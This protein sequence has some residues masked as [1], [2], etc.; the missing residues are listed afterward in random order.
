MLG[1]G[2]GSLYVPILLYC[3]INFHTA[4]TTS[5]LMLTSGSLSAVYVF[6][7][8]GM[9]D[10]KLVTVLGIPSMLG[11]FIGGLIS[12][13]FNVYAL[14]IIFSVTLFIASY[15][16]I[17]EN[18]M[19]EG[20]SYHFQF[21]PFIMHRSFQ[22]NKYRVDLVL[23]GILV[24]LVGFLGGLIGVAGGWFIVPMLV[25]LFS[26]PMR[27]AVATSSVVVLLNGT[28]GITGHGLA[29]HINWQLALWLSI[30]A[31]IGAQVG[32]RIS[33]RVKVN[34]LRVVFAF[35]LCLVGVWVMVKNVLVF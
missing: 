15:L 7:K 10:L 33:I 21:S 13:H 17:Q 20:K 31:I 9:V 18:S 35:V 14:Y 1:L 29:G 30:L 27:I 6:Y 2:G 26:V 25:L 28:A 22:G 34:L 19:K 24:L 16:M 4:T 5:L 3:G 11:A 32:S 8:S 23:A 12:G